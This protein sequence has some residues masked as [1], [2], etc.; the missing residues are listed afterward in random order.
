MKRPPRKRP[1]ALGGGGAHTN[2]LSHTHTHKRNHTLPPLPPAP[3]LA[4]LFPTS[5]SCFPLGL[6]PSPAQH[7]HPSPTLF[8]FPHPSSFPLLRKL[9]LSSPL[10]PVLMLPLPLPIFLTSA[11]L[12]RLGSVLCKN[13]S[14]FFLIVLSQQR[15]FYHKCVK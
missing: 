12:M 14:A 5:H 1:R 8:F 13:K 11:F 3:P 6:L 7:P 4:R 10:P 15:P 2:S 9:L